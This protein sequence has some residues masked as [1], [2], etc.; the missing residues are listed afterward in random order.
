MFRIGPWPALALALLSQPA[1]P[2]TDAELAQIRNEIR[3]LRESYEARIQA[4][5]QRLKEAEARTAAP[6]QTAAAPA[7]A[8]VAPVTTGAQSAQSA[9]NPAIS[10][11][12]TGTYAHL[13]KDP[14]AFSIPGFSPEG[15]IGPGRRGFGLGESELV[16][17]ANVD[18]LFFANLTL[19]VTPEDT[20]EVEEAYGRFNAPHGFA[21]RFGRFLSGVGYVNE[22]H[23]HAWDFVD[24]PLAYQAFFG[25]HYRADGVQV[26]WVAPTETFLELGGEVGNGDSFPGSERNRNG[27]GAW[28]AYAHLGGDIGDSHSWRAG[29]SYLDTKACVE[30]EADP[31]TCDDRRSKLSIADFVWKWSPRG[32]IRERYVK[33]QGEYLSGRVRDNVRQSAWY[34]QGVWQ[35]LP[36]WRVGARYDRLDPNGV[37]EVSYAPRKAAVMLDWNPSEFSRIRLQFARSEMLAGTTDTQFFVQYILSLGAHGAHRY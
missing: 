12:L 18:P 37:D 8:A 1:F 10:A 3:A 30:S 36:E 7:Q 26:K 5:E 16:F 27:A 9:F 28:A 22:Q 14:R 23:A 35:F 11:I 19:A 4:L 21:P 29:F 33:L 2:A 32:N 31:G 24:L 13:S 17:T 6:A 34:L 20:V 15:E 25:G